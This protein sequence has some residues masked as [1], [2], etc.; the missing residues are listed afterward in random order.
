MSHLKRGGAVLALL[1]LGLA[2][3][4]QQA[5]QPSQQP[6]NDDVV[7]IDS[8]LVL[9]SVT[10]VD[11][12]GK[13]VEGLGRE[14]FELKVDGKPVPASFVERVSA[15][16]V[17]E[18][19]LT[20]PRAGEA[21]PPRP[22]AES[23]SDRGRVI[24]F[25]VDDMHLTSDSLQRTRKAISDFVENDMGLSDQVAIASPTGQ[26]GFLQQFADNKAVLRAA[27]A[28]LSHRNFNVRDND[29]IPMTEYQ[30]LRIDQGDRDT[31]SYYTA[32][33]MKETNFRVM[34]G[35][36][37]PPAGGPLNQ[38]LPPR[39]NSAGNTRDTAERQV[40]GR[41]SRILQQSAAVSI[42][43]LSALESL[44]RSSAQLPGRKLVFFFSDGFFLNDRET[45]FGD[46]LRAITDAAVRAG[47]VIYS[48]DARGLTTM[49]DASSNRADPTG[50][51]SRANVGELAASQDPLTAL[52]GDTGG[53]ALL[54][55]QALDSAVSKALEETSNY[56]LLAWRPDPVEQKGGKFKKLQVSIAGR[57]DLAVR[58]P[59]GYLDS[60]P[61]AEPPAR[62][63]GQ[64]GAASPAPRAAASA[65]EAALREAVQSFVPRH[66]LPTMLDV[67]F[68]D[69]P[70]NGAVLSASAQVDAASLAYGADGK[71][72]AVVDL[73]GI[74][75]NTEGKSVGGFKTRLDV[76]P[77]GSGGE[78]A[79]GSGGVVYVYRLPLPPGIYQ[80]RVGARD[81]RSGKVGSAYHWLEVPDLKSRQ[82]TL[83]SLM[84]REQTPA[85]PP[86]GA[87][88]QP[89]QFSVDHKF[90]RSSRLNFFMFIYNGA[91][92]PAAQPD[93]GAQ[94]QVFRDGR[95]VV[96]T[97]LRPLSMQGVPD[98]ARI[99]YT[100][101]FPL[102]TLAPGRYLLQITVADRAG[103]RTATQRTVFTVE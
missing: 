29:Q 72:P 4:A 13:F 15:G 65:S 8:E 89:V 30:A 28:R 86:A 43:T 63:V 88:E 71:A 12:Q 90:S 50:Q 64:A 74:V 75:L 40:K 60:P 14:Q 57:P 37:G 34:G 26:L 101:S 62:Q 79:P 94:V 47:V 18:R 42:G 87:A 46:K 84:V 82:L 92:T 54:N 83:S 36:L 70:D 35:P 25:F 49:T 66:G 99:P 78:G 31:I 39:S 23:A 81:D 85:P 6:Q 98:L 93:L 1:L 77:V 95:A 51:L 100:G 20:A 67:A 55:I 58:L 48:V 59:R 19:A 68:I 17:R 3:A 91:P 56:Y 22:R 27:L 97:P 76:K 44:M 2:A 103:Q 11:K 24:I 7:R 16:S 32:Q 52:A 61:A 10:V 80:V 38:K 69:T 45:G 33:L 9:T 73:A 96:N 5:Q 41:A 21:A 102:Q 53:R